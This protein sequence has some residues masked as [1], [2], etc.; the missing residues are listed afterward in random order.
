MINYHASPSRIIIHI[1]VMI[2]L[3]S[4]VYTRSIKG[5]TI[6]TISLMICKW[7]LF[8]INITES[9][10]LSSPFFFKQQGSGGINTLW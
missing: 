4:Y 2:F 6:I 9:R 10:G 3:Y 1:D 7:Y 8:L 5:P